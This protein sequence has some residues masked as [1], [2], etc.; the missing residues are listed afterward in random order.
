MKYYFLYVLVAFNFCFLYL[1]H[2]SYWVS[3]ASS[4]IILVVTFN[5]WLIPYPQNVPWEKQLMRPLYLTHAIYVFYMA[6]TSCFAYFDALGYRFFEIVSYPK[7]NSYFETFAQAQFYYFLFHIGMIQGLGIGSDYRHIKER[8]YKKGISFILFRILWLGTILSIVFS[9]IPSLSQFHEKF[10]SLAGV[11]ASISLV[12][13]FREKKWQV[14]SVVAIVWT[15]NMYKAVTSG[16]KES[17]LV[18]LILI[19]TYLYPF[20]KRTVLYVGLPIFFAILYILPFYTAI[21][22]EQ[23]WFG[24]TSANNAATSAVTQLQVTNS[25]DV[26]QFN[27]DVLASRL[28]EIQLFIPYIKHTPHNRPYYGFDLLGQALKGLLPRAF[29]PDKPIMERMAMERV[30]ENKVVENSAVLS[31]KPQLV[32]DGYLSFGTLGTWLFGLIFG[33]SAAWISVWL[34]ESFGSYIIGSG[35]LFNSLFSTYWRGNCVEFMFGT[36]FWSV[37]TAFLLKVFLKKLFST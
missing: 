29:Y 12:L 4:I 22:R 3:W 27:W 24:N 36:V 6:I 35:L 2:I 20:Y 23:T 10:N 28:S 34:E 30:V 33:W 18:P 25:K 5:G 16:W 7:S 9:F 37:V 17:V 1:P 13:S 8:V 19:G 26:L 14:F 11:G 21:V 15:F 32:V 31:A